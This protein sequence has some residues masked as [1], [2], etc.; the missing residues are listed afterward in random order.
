MQNCTSG[1]NSTKWWCYLDG[2][3]FARTLATPIFPRCFLTFFV[4]FLAFCKYLCNHWE[5]W[6]GTSGIGIRMQNWTSGVNSTKWW[7]YLDGL[8]FARTLATPI[9]P[10]CFLT[11]FV[12]FLA[13][14]KYLCNHWEFWDGTSGI[15]IRMQN[16]TS[17]VNST[18]WWCYLDGLF[19]ARTLATPIFP[20]CFLTFFVIFLA[21]CKYLCNH[22]EFWDGTSGIGIRMQNWTSGVN[23]TKW[24]CYL[25]G[26]L[27]ARTL[28]TPIFPRCFLTFFV[29]FLA[30]CK[31]LCNH[32]EFWDGT[33]GIGIRM[34]NWTSGVNSTKW[35]CYLD[36]LLFARTLATP[37]FPRCFLT[38]FV[39]FLAFCKYLCN[40]WEFWDGTSGIGIRMQNCTS[41]VNSTKWWCY[42]D[43]LL[44]ARTLATPI[45]PR[46]F[47]TFFVI[48][49]AFCKYL[50]NHWE[51]WDGTSGI[52]IR[53]QN[54]TSGVN[55]TKWWCY[56]DGLF[57]ART[58]ATPIF[59]RCF[60]TFFVIFL[61]F[62]KYLCN[63]WE[64]WDGTSGIG[65]RMQNCTSGVNSTKWWC[66]LDGL[67]FAR[68]LATPIF[69][70]CFLT[71]F[72]IFLAFCKYLCNHWEF[73]DGTSGIGIRMQNCTSG[74]NSTKWWCYRDGLFFARTLA[75]PI[76]PR[77]FLTF[78]V[79]FLAFCKYLCNHW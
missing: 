78:F 26:L 43:G 62:C 73:W 38:F 59:P 19:F 64:F 63:H 44:F 60:L 58:L 50:C 74:V 42:L 75:T 51:F 69:P 57:F 61:A 46:C 22:W 65:I 54:W 40:H 24:W 1:V 37:I 55:S 79:I 49:L 25:D 6:D 53:M 29:I 47:L 12:I 71:F 66:Y 45:F 39:I 48:F 35:W 2:L 41:G 30:F 15:G 68:T 5:F 8:F 7:C 34:Q 77:C 56:L 21:F 31:Y 18:K 67:L 17:G 16:C 36:G 9:F 23:S 4:I 76:F 52:G 32:W 13:F 27:F 72:V 70:R 11:F 28:A 20:R 14:C 3:L 10:R 33:S